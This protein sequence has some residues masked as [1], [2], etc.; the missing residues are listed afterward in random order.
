MDIVLLEV[1]IDLSEIIDG[2]EKVS[3]EEVKSQIDNKNIL[4]YLINKYK[5][6]YDDIKIKDMTDWRIEEINNSI[7]ENYHSSHNINKLPIYKNNGLC[8]L[9]GIIIKIL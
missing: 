9:I 3:L 5:N 1:L 6:K 2:G 4:Q 7:Y 8:F